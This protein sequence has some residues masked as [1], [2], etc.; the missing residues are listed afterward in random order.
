M[1]IADLEIVIEIDRGM[2]GLRRGELLPY[3]AGLLPIGNG[4]GFKRN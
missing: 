4:G 2:W 1:I 3:P